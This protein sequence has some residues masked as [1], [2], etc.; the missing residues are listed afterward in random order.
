MR[1]LV[2]WFILLLPF[3][4]GA[5]FYRWVDDEGVMQ[6]TQQPPPSGKDASRM[7][8]EG[9]GVSTVEAESSTFVPENA[10]SAKPEPTLS[11][12]Q[13]RMRDDLERA[14]Q[15]RQAEIKRIRQANCARAYEVLERLSEPSRIRV[16]DSSGKERVMPESERMARI[17]DA[18]RGIVEN[19]AA[20]A[21]A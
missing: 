14:E 15:A 11:P 10:A 5:E 8:L 17:E 6:F 20:S 16:R 2:L 9:A 3:L 7:R 12:Q 21:D 4:M 19:C 13:Q 18:Q 1:V